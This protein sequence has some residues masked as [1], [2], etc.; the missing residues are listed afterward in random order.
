[1][2][3]MPKG[4]RAVDPETGYFEPEMLRFLAQLER[5]TIAAQVPATADAKGTT[6]AIASDADHIYVCVS[7]DTWKRAAL[8]TW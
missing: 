7:T 1:V 3:K 5:A 6:G 4:G 8:S 2:N